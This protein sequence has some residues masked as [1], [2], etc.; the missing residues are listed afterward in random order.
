[1]ADDRVNAARI[2]RAH[3]RALR[4]EARMLASG[5]AN[6]QADR[7]RLIAAV[8]VAAQAARCEV[9]ACDLERHALEVAS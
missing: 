7:P 4:D 3:A 2:L 6:L 1:M 5:V 8:A 9:S